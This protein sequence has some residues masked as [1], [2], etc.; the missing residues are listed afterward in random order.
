MSLRHAPV[1]ADPSPTHG[2]RLELVLQ[3]GSRAFE[4][5]SVVLKPS[6]STPISHQ[7]TPHFT[8]SPGSVVLS[9]LGPKPKPIATAASIEG[10]TDGFSY[11]GM[12]DDTDATGKR[13]VDGNLAATRLGQTTTQRWGNE[14]FR[15][16]M[17]L[18]LEFRREW[19]GQSLLTTDDVEGIRTAIDNALA[20]AATSS[21]VG[22]IYDT[23]PTCWA[24]WLVQRAHTLK[25][26]G[27][28]AGTKEIQQRLS[29][30]H[31]YAWLQAQHSRRQRHDL[32]DPDTKKVVHRYV[33]PF[34]RFVVP[35]PANLLFKYRKSAQR[36]SDWIVRGS[37]GQAPGLAAGVIAQAPAALVAPPPSSSSPSSLSSSSSTPSSSSS[38]SPLGPAPP[39]S[40]LVLPS[41]PLL[42]SCCSGLL[43]SLS[44]SGGSLPIAVRMATVIGSLPATISAAAAVS[45]GSRVSTRAPLGFC[46]SATSDDHS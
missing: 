21:H 29:F 36:L 18:I 31:L 19:P 13:K 41:S 39:P 17:L 45:T 25:A 26:G 6:F 7:A 22:D 14:R 4:R 24:I 43:G 35:P 27:W 9:L 28:T 40:P 30:K 46:V 3:A 20:F 23:N 44:Q 10:L 2:S 33:L 34:K 12:E 37:D 42:L 16:T 8:G 1:V 5:R 32:V 38:P 11:L 15:Q